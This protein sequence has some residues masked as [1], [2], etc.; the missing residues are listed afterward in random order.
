[1]EIILAVFS[2][3]TLIASMAIYRDARIS[4]NQVDYMIE[5]AVEDATN[6]LKEK[7]S[8]LNHTYWT[9]KKKYNLNISL[10]N[11]S[12]D[13]VNDLYH[14]IH[15]LEKER[16]KLIEDKEASQVYY[17]KRLSEQRELRA[18]NNR[19]KKE[20]EQEK[21]ESDEQF[22]NFMHVT[23]VASELREQLHQLNPYACITSTNLDE[24]DF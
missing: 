1:M 10:L 22:H 8:D 5:D 24:I 20:L 9:L 23:R 15:H 19:L 14:R 2:I 3:I 4:M 13:S 18:E 17:K 7:I 12:K 21:A 6:P 11:S 16:R